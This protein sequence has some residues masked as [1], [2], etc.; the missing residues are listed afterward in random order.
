MLSVEEAAGRILAAF[1]RLDPE[2]TPIL[3]SLGLLLA[4]DVVATFDIPPLANSAMDGYAVRSEDVRGAG[5]E[6]P[7]GLG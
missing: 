7:A 2:P 3:E 5:P 4:E 6:S 1:S